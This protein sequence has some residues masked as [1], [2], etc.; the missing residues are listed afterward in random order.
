MA[1]SHRWTPKVEHVRPLVRPVRVDPTGERGPTR[2]EAASRRYWRRTTRGLYVPVDTR[3]DLP[4]QHILEQAARLP[5]GAAVTGW[6]GCRLFGANFF[7]GLAPDGQTPLPVTLALGPRRNLKPTS[8]TKLNFANFA[9]TEVTTRH[10]VPV[11]SRERCT[12]DAA[13][14]AASR[15][16]GLAEIVVVFDMVQAAE[17][18]SGD[19]LRTYAATNPVSQRLRRAL[20]LSSEHSRS[21]NESRLRVLWEVDAGLPRPL[22][23]AP[24]FDDRGRLLGIADLFDRSSGLVVEFDGADHRGLTRHTADVAKDEA[25]RQAGLEVTRVTGADLRRPNL[26]VRRLTQARERAQANQTPRAMWRARIPADD[27]EIRLAT[28]EVE[29]RVWK[30]LDA[31]P[32]PDIQALANR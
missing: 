13:R 20:S 26:V 27:L 21:P 17:L 5:S 32:L 18:T 29:D 11:L 4:E 23:N 3:R 8:L 9:P 31:Q 2:A 16:V 30:E 7:D 12:W 6:A 1:N 19:R 10:G 25:L 15:S 28:R 22:V 14:E 24:I